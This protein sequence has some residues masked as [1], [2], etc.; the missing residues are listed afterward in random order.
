MTVLIANETLADYSRNMRYDLIHES[1]SGFF[2]KV[3]QEAYET[4]KAVSGE[5][6]PST[7]RR[8]WIDTFSQAPATSSASCLSSARISPCKV[9]GRRSCSC[10]R[11]SRSRSKAASPASMP[12]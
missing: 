2:T 7:T 8:A 5:T 9:P 4:A 1:P 11:T 12:I 6:C 10:A 3:M